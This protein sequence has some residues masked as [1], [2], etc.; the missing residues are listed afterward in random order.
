MVARKCAL[1][2]DISSMNSELNRIGKPKP[3]YPVGEA[4]RVV[5]TTKSGSFS[6]P[7]TTL[8]IT[9]GSAN[10]RGENVT[11]VVTEEPPSHTE[12]ET[13][14]LETQDTDEDK[15]E[16]EQVFEEP[17][18]AV[19]I[20]SNPLKLLKYNQSLLMYRRVVYPVRWEFRD[21][22]FF[23]LRDWHGFCGD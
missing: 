23:S 7:Q 21:M 22:G 2:E 4:T 9:R 8:A 10:V 5:S 12:W 19:P 17:K 11:P 20:S 16:K 15:V 6:V 3:H 1:V 14:D 13:E 18:H